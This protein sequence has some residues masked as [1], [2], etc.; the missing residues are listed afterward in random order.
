M[1]QTYINSLKKAPNQPNRELLLKYIK[2]YLDQQREAVTEYRE[3][4][5]KPE[6]SAELKEALKEII[7]KYEYTEKFYMEARK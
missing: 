1:I 7:E 6:V 2:D 5:D 3:L 4:L